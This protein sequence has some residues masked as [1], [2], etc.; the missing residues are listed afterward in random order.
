LALVTDWRWQGDILYVGRAALNIST[1]GPVNGLGVLKTLVPGTPDC[2]AV[3]AGDGLNGQDGQ[4]CPFQMYTISGRFEVKTS[5][6]YTFC[7]SSTEG[8]NLYI[9]GALIVNNDYPQ[10]SAIQRCGSA[11]TLSTGTHVLYIEGW[12]RGSTLS[13]AGTYKGPDTSQ[14]FAAI[15]PVPPPI[16]SPVNLSYFAEC[17]PAHS[18]VTDSGIFTLCGFK[19]DNYTDIT[20]VEDFYQ[21]YEQGNVTYVDSSTL[22]NLKVKR[23]QFPNIIAGLP[24]HQFGYVLFGKMEIYMNGS[25]T[26]CSRS[27]DGLVG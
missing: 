6:A 23:N 26:F 14:S 7:T 3:P 5:G 8:S 10:G 2:R 16:I 20:S 18:N 9:N 17:D 21:Y 11:V 27:D 22:I 13:M 4:N 1:I 12:A 19:A 25:Y 15:R 24:N